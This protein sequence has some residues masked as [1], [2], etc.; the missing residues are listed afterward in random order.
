MCYHCA[1][2]MPIFPQTLVCSRFQRLGKRP[3]DQNSA[4]SGIA[5]PAVWALRLF[6]LGALRP[7]GIAGA[8][9]AHKLKTYFQLPI[10]ILMFDLNLLFGVAHRENALYNPSS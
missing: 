4:P 1:M 7:N 3:V 9:E 6:G 8:G 2:V 5:G 10:L